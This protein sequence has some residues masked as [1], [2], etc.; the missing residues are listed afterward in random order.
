[1]HW[2]PSTVTIVG[3]ATICLLGGCLGGPKIE[4]PTFDSQAAAAGAMR[5]HDTNKDGQI[6]GNELK[7]CPGLR[8]ASSR[9]DTN[10]DGGFS[11]EEIATLIEFYAEI[12]LALAPFSCQVL[13]NN[14]PLQGATIRLVPVE[15][16]EGMIQP[17]EGMTDESGNVLPATDDPVAKAEGVT[18]VNPGFYRVEIS[19]V[20][21]N[22]QETIPAKYNTETTLGCHVGHIFHGMGTRFELSSR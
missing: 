9:L 21:G 12:R 17:A 15:F 8:A 3:L 22:G 11:V 10:H 6:S 14:R 19:R 13:M 1:M 7:Q 4:E 2:N 20:D 18:G 16:L 5:L